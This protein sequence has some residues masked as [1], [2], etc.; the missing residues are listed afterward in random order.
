MKNLKETSFILPVLLAAALSYL[1]VAVPFSSVAAEADTEADVLIIHSFSRMDEWTEILHNKIVHT[2]LSERPSVNFYIEY[3]D[4]RHYIGDGFLFDLA[5]MYK[6]KYS[7]QNL[8]LVICTGNYACELIRYY[9]SYLFPDVPVVLS[10]VGNR[11]FEGGIGIERK[12]VTGVAMNYTAVETALL[13]LKLQ[14]ETENIALL[15]DM[16]AGPLENRADFSFRIDELPAEVNIIDLPVMTEEKLGERLAALPKDTVILDMGCWCSVDGNSYRPKGFMRFLRQSS[17]LPVYATDGFMVEKYGALGGYVNFAAEHGVLTGKKV[18]DILGGVPVSNIPVTL[19][20]PSGYVV[21]R[22]VMLRRG[23][24][25]ADIP[26]GS[27]IFNEQKSF[28]SLYGG[29]VIPYLVLISFLFLVA[30]YLFDNIRKKKK[31]EKALIREKTFMKQLF[32][33]SP[34]GIVLLDEDGK[35]LRANLEMERLFKV[36]ANSIIG[37][38]LENVPADI[39]FITDEQIDLSG[40]IA[41]GRN[42]RMEA[43]IC[44]T[45]GIKIPLMVSK[46]SFLVGGQ[47]MVY[48]IYRDISERKRSGERLRKRLGFEE[49]ISKTS[50]GMVFGSELGKLIEDSFCDL[51]LMM[52][53]VKGYIVFFGEKVSVM[54]GICQWVFVN[55]KTL[56]VEKVLPLSDESQWFMEYLREF[57]QLIAEDIGSFDIPENK[58]LAFAGGFHPESLIVLPFYN[59]NRIHGY[60]TICN[61]WPDQVWNSQDINLV[62]IYRDIVGEAFLRK[63]SEEKLQ[64]NLESLKKTF[65]GTIDSVGKILEVK[66]PFTAGHQR[67][68][69]RLAVAIAMEFCLDKERITGLYYAALVH[70]IGKINIPSEILNKPDRLTSLEEELVKQHSRYGW[71]I[72]TKVD[73]PWPIAE[74]VFQHHERVDGSGYPRGLKGDQILLEA[75]IL[76]VSDIVEAMSFD[77]PCRP[78]LGINNALENIARSSGTY[79]DAEVVRVCRSVFMEKGFTFAESSSSVNV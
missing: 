7:S 44:R 2:I 57:G 13:A 29:I 11:M 45:D 77:R 41:E 56:P 12:N 75:R 50:S 78:S 79:Y 40:L 33:N 26:K 62:R 16:T 28:F 32:E 60:M 27:L 58:L 68:V 23:I 39:S 72:L 1:L 31:A 64:R 15:Y 5:M 10:G 66:D 34:E 73:L 4:S 37:S 18:L 47:T 69:A 76:A 59:V 53:A 21:N 36:P 48:E 52:S 63:I 43:A 22:A 25:D 74:I 8:N 71:E 30:V 55:G 67:R 35:V 24:S 61:P 3:M 46:T 51:C 49:F 19:D 38:K 42:S 6:R 20:G 65:E 70:D 9:G 14:P 54:E 17:S